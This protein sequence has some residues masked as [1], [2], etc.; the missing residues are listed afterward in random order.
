MPVFGNYETVDTWRHEGPYV[1]YLARTAGTDE[2]P[3]FFVKTYELLP[4]V[5][6]EEKSRALVESF[7]QVAKLQQELA[8]SG[9]RHWAPIY[10]CAPLPDG[11]GAY[12]V[13][14]YFAQSAESLVNSLVEL[15]AYSLYGIVKGVAEALLEIK[16]ACGRTH[17]GLR[18]SCILLDEGEEGPHS[19][20]LLA[21]PRPDGE[22]DPTQAEA[23]DLRAVGLA[24]YQ[25]ITHHPFDELRDAPRLASEKWPWLGRRGRRWAKL[26]AELLGG[27]LPPGL[28]TVEALAG[29]L[30]ALR[31]PRRPRVRTRTLAVTGCGAALV[32]LAASLGLWLLWPRFDVREWEKV[33]VAYQDLTVALQEETRQRFQRDPYLQEIVTLVDTAEELDPR[34]IAN[35]PDATL[36]ELREALPTGRESRAALG[37]ARVAL[38]LIRRIDERLQDWPFLARLG[39]LAQDCDAFGLRREAAIIRHRVIA[40]VTVEEGERPL[41][42]VAF[43]CRRRERYESMLQSLR[44]IQ[45]ACQEIRGFTL[46]RGMLPDVPERVRTE[47]AALNGKPF[48]EVVAGLAATRALV[49]DIKDY[50]QVISLRRELTGVTD[51]GKYLETELT[52]RSPADL[53]SLR[54]GLQET[55]YLMLRI[56]RIWKELGRLATSAGHA[57]PARRAD[58]RLTWQPGEAL[59]SLAE[60]LEA[61]KRESEP[62]GEPEPR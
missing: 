30:R 50:G 25:L 56:R 34:R 21:A 61:L 22:A 7:L 33:C 38:H 11:R 62:A 53:R 29:R 44:Q 41:E 23:D 4:E 5:A 12:Y 55:K 45:K 42:A 9:A 19:S 3:R 2:P 20:A 52:S 13:S 48:D 16:R 49:E 28:T 10:E 24:I 26:C 54:N 40:R 43:A 39:E 36:A 58:H 37:R 51:L 14:D 57:D 60:K 18:P 8:Q 6:D 35:R 31:P 59:A 17:G 1:D 32:V 47:V 46:P 15:N 27:V